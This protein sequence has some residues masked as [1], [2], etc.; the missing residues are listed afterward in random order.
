MLLRN[1]S[2]QVKFV[3]DPK[4]ANDAPDE[5]AL[6]G[7]VEVAAAYAEIFKNVVTH[8]ALVVGGA[9]ILCKIVER[10]CR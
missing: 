3:K 2:V 4:T 9:F 7:N 1:R 5:A 8:T 6:I 10:I